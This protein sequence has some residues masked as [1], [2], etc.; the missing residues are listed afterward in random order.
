MVSA[1]DTMIE[2]SDEP[3]G[4]FAQSGS[5]LLKRVW[6]RPFLRGCSSLP[7]CQP[8]GSHT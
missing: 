6:A 8:S 7:I 2:N 4:F 5:F 1:G 3:T